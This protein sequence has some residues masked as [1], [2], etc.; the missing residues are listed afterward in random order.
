MSVCM[1]VHSYS[2]HM[3][4]CTWGGGNYPIWGR[5]V[6]SETNDGSETSRCI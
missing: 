3:V 6:E 5:F 2:G 4:G 1:R